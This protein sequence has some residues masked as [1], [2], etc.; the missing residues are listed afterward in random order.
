MLKYVMKDSYFKIK[1]STSFAS[2]SDAPQNK[3][4]YLKVKQDIGR[5]SEN[6]RKLEFDRSD[7]QPVFSEEDSDNIFKFSKPPPIIVGAISFI[8]SNKIQIIQYLTKHLSREE[9]FHEIKNLRNFLTE[10]EIALNSFIRI[11]DIAYNRIL[12]FPSFDVEFG[13]LDPSIQIVLHEQD[14][15]QIIFRTIVSLFTNLESLYSFEKIFKFYKKDL[16]E[17]EEEQNRLIDFNE[18]TTKAQKSTEKNNN[19]IMM[20]EKDRTKVDIAIRKREM[21]IECYN[22]LVA[23]SHKNEKTQLFLCQYIP[24]M[25]MHSYFFPEII[26]V[27]SSLFSS[28]QEILLKL[29]SKFRLST[30]A[31]ED[32]EINCDSAYKLVNLKKI[33]EEALDLIKRF[34]HEE[35]IS[36]GASNVFYFYCYYLLKTTSIDVRFKILDLFSS[37]SSFRGEGFNANQE[38]IFYQIQTNFKELLKNQFYVF[39]SRE[40]DIIVM[41]PNSLS[42]EKLH[43][44]FVDEKE[45]G[46]LEN[47]PNFKGRTGAMKFTRR[48]DKLFT[49]FDEEKMSINSD[50]RKIE[51]AIAALPYETIPRGT[52]ESQ[53][54]RENLILGNLGGERLITQFSELGENLLKEEGLSMRN[55]EVTSEQK[56]Y[57]LKQINFYSGMVHDRNYI[58][59]N[60]LER[61]GYFSFETLLENFTRPFNN[62]EVNSGLTKLLIQMYEDQKPMYYLVVPQYA[63]ILYGKFRDPDEMIS[64]I[65]ETKK[66]RATSFNLEYLMADEKILAIQ[67][68]VGEYFSMLRKTIKAFPQCFEDLRKDEK[69]EEFEENKHKVINQGTS[70]I[71]NLVRQI[72]DFGHYTLNVRP[73]QSRFLPTIL[74][75]GNENSDLQPLL[76]T[77]IKILEFEPDYPEA[78]HLLKSLIKSMQT[79]KKERISPASLDEKINK[80]RYQDEY[81]KIQMVEDVEKK[82]E[83]EMKSSESY[84]RQY[85]SRDLIFKNEFKQRNTTLENIKLKIIKILE[86]VIDFLIDSYA[87]KV[88]RE[89]EKVV[90]ER[91]LD[92]R[93]KNGEFSRNPEELDRIFEQTLKEKIKEITPPLAFTG[94]SLDITNEDLK[95][96]ELREEEL[97]INSILGQS[98]FPSLLC[99]FAFNQD[100]DEISTKSISLLIK[101]FSQRIQV[102]NI[103]KEVMVV[104]GL[105]SIGDYLKIRRDIN[106]LVDICDESEIWIKS[107]ENIREKNLNKAI[108]IFDWFNRLISAEQDENLGT[109]G[110][111]VDKNVFNVNA[112]FQNLFRYIKANEVAVDF[113]RDTFSLLNTFEGATDPVFVLFMQTVFLFL[114]KF[115]Y[116]NPENQA[117][118]GKDIPVFLQDALLD[119]GQS[120][121]IIEIYKD[122]EDMCTNNYSWV[123]DDFIKWIFK[124]GRR[125]KFIDFFLILMKCNDD[126]LIDNQRRILALFL[127]HPKRNYLLFCSEIKTENVTSIEFDFEPK[128]LI[129]DRFYQDEPYLYHSKVMKLLCYACVGKSGVNVNEIKVRNFFKLDYLLKILK[130]DDSFLNRREINKHFM[131][132]HELNGLNAPKPNFSYHQGRVEA[133]D[134]E[135]DA[136]G[137]SGEGGASLV[138]SPGNSSPLEL[139]RPKFSNM[140]SRPRPRKVILPQKNRKNYG[141]SEIKPRKI[142]PAEISIFNCR[143]KISVLEFLYFVHFESNVVSEEL[144][145]HSAFFI[146]FF[147]KENQR[148]SGITPPDISSVYEEYLFGNLIRTA[149][150]VNGIIEEKKDIGHSDGLKESGDVFKI[151]DFI[152]TLVEKI[153]IFSKITLRKYS[154]DVEIISTS[155]NFQIDLSLQKEVFGKLEETEDQKI[156]EKDI[157][158]V[159]SYLWKKFSST[160]AI[161]KEIKEGISTEKSILSQSLNKIEEMFKIPIIDQGGLELKVKIVLTNISKR[162]VIKSIIKFILSNYKDKDRR[163]IVSEVVFCLAG[164]IP[165]DKNKEINRGNQEAVEKEQNFLQECGAT[166]MVMKLFSDAQLDLKTDDLTI[167]LLNFSICL[168]EGGNNRVQREMFIYMKTQTAS[169]VFFS[170]I[171][172]L[173][174]QETE[175]SS[176]G[177]PSLSKEIVLLILKLIQRLAE[178]HYKDMQVYLKAQTSSHRSFNLLESVVN[179]VSGYINSRRSENYP[180]IVQGFD[181]IT[182]LIQGPCYENQKALIQGRLMEAIGK[183]LAA[184]EFLLIEAKSRGIEVPEATPWTFRPWML[185]RMKHRC[186]IVLVSLIECRLDN[187]ILVKIHSNLKKYLSENICSFYI[188]FQQIYG[189][190][191]EESCLEHLNAELGENRGELYC[192]VIIQTAF[193]FYTIMRSYEE[194][195]DEDEKEEEEG[196]EEE[197]S[198]FSIL[199]KQFSLSR[200]FSA[201]MVFSVKKET[202]KTETT[203]G[204]CGTL[205]ELKA[206]ISG[207]RDN[208]RHKAMD[209]MKRKT[210]AIEVVRSD[211]KLERTYFLSLPY[212]EAITDEIKDKFNQEVC[213]DSCKTK[214]NDLLEK[215]FVLTQ[216]LKKERE[217]LR[218]R[219]SS[220]D[221]GSPAF[222]EELRSIEGV[223]I[224]LRG[225][226][227]FDHFDLVQAVPR[228]RFR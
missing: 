86:T 118:L 74:H 212:F 67:K 211:G 145:L 14:F 196:M 158:V 90:T 32:S 134:I 205:E 217:F 98:M 60:N 29:K 177:T 36:S 173:F 42:L 174:H 200:S 223:F 75:N 182:E 5:V 147:L 135:V 61:N 99:V 101:V 92:T 130:Q 66:K 21:M 210:N 8:L 180:H 221:A 91:E 34:A 172:Y 225:S 117:L 95:N 137:G 198:V 160:Y 148:L 81:D 41:N 168:L 23:L 152:Q 185:A 45:P 194:I 166:E 40:K 22:I 215:S 179:L 143:M 38:E 94:L 167:Q 112:D 111:L 51:N 2:G 106:S 157:P 50:K 133:E 209:F 138:N 100:S 171:Y 165:L 63:K 9:D 39:S 53:G 89:F 58:W 176:K 204:D 55:L 49:G 193:N 184:D 186:S 78:L 64:K 20:S 104:Q 65:P 213:R 43:E 80:F 159:W 121:L 84:F 4:Y 116:K 144:M 169:Y 132:L 27:I 201:K 24:L 226:N 190:S 153:E 208:V 170:K 195:E 26:S 57:I 30:S 107:S 124:F 77:M 218:N 123:S 47:S 105:D 25:Q 37:F 12:E 140:S 207:Q 52:E 83:T 103:V 88:V 181:T 224:L 18:T 6:K 187:S 154:K 114:R 136:D 151:N 71:L 56:V 149:S 87:N 19:R 220:S 127:E 191:Y 59:K 162:R 44:L 35:G 68:K 97:N 16:A 72:L 219:V 131:M 102:M 150:A 93:V 128:A 222:D 155:F 119:L 76:R 120:S 110:N 126:Y 139:G 62:P 206:R 163:E 46:A 228:R 11:K 13:R 202:E 164:M 192:S 108:N 197:E 7:L 189:D 188:H 156:V 96:T 216:Q 146:E 48:E 203:M 129:E 33:D 142:S 28:N 115:C 125:Q 175:L 178:G 69:Y 199:Q 17:Q 73:S 15:I 141:Q 10:T 1:I 183:L 214:C 79:F 85:F 54:F 31:S 3:P 109:T 113:I 122:N 161:N 82:D 227:E 70:E